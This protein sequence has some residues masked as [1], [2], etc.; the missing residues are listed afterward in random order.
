M[1][2]AALW[3]KVTS[4]KAEAGT[5]FVQDPESARYDGMPRSAIETGLADIVAR[6]E[7]MPEKLVQF[8]RHSTLSGSLNGSR[9][10]AAAE[11]VR[12]PLQQVF[13]TMR[14][15][16]GHDFSRYKLATIRRRLQ[17]RMSVNE[18][19]DTGE[20]ARYL[21]E[22]DDEVKA[23]LK[24]LLISV[25]NLFRD[26]DA[27]EA[28]RAQMLTVLKGKA[29]GSELR[30]WVAGCATGEEAYSVAIVVSECLSELEKRL[31][32]QMYGTDI[33]ID[34]LHVARTGLYPANI[35]ADVT[36]ERL[37][38]FFVKEKE[39]YRIKKDIR[40][41]VVF[42]P[43]NFIK[44]PPFSR[45]D[46]ICCR[47][48]LIYLEA[49]VQK[50]VLPLLH[51]A[52][53]PGGILFLGPS[54][55]VGEATDLFAT[56]DRKWKIYQ[57]REVTVPAERL[58]FPASFAPALRGG[59][60][61][62]GG[63]PA[64]VAEA[65]RIPQLTEKIFLDHY[66]PTFAII[67][68][69]YRLVYVRGR[70]GRFL[71]IASGQPSLSVLE[72][73]REGLR[74][75]LASAVYRASSERKLIVHDGVRVKNNGG[76]Q[77]VNLTVAPLTEPGIPPGFL[78]V[79]FQEVGTATGEEKPRPT[80][81]AHKRVAQLEEDL[82]LSRENLQTT[83]EEL[84]A[85][86][87]ELKSANEELQSNNEELQSTNEELD[88]SREELQSLNEELTTLN[89]ELQDKNELLT[90]ANDDLRNFLNR[91]DIAI[92]FLDEELKIRSFTPATADVFNIRD[93]DV[94]RPLGDIT[95]RLAYDGIVDDAQ[96]V[97]RSLKAKEVEVQRKDGCWYKLRILPYLTTQNA[98]GGLVLSLL[99]IDEQKKAVESLRETKDYLDKLFDNASAPIIVWDPKSL[100]TRFNHAF[101]KLTGRKADEVLGKRVDFLIP[102]AG[103]KGAL[104]KIN[105]SARKREP[106]DNV[107]VQIQHA[108]GSVRTL[109]WNSATVLDTDGKTPLGTIAQGVD[110][111]ERK[112]VETLKD[113][114]IGLVSHEMRTPLTVI[115][116]AVKTALDDRI[117]EA[118]RREL[119]T[120][121]SQAAESLGDILDN[122]L[123]LSRHQANRL[124]LRRRATSVAELAGQVVAE[125]RRTPL[126]HN[127][128]L[129]VPA[130]LPQIVVD[131]V[132]FQRVLHNLLENALKYAPEQTD[133]RV[134]ARLEDRQVVVG[135]SDQGPGISLEDQAKLFE[136]F[137]RLKTI[138]PT[139]GVGLG[140]VVCK[141]LVEAHGGRIWLESRPGEGST[142]LFTVPLAS[143]KAD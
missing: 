24:D 40:E 63:E 113:E 127:I 6:P 114:F 95:S 47:N 23:F 125:F 79:V 34:A 141:R 19:S 8:V 13:A 99:D 86:N 130:G 49:D 52:L 59:A 38:R 129:D 67:D 135:V 143:K 7:D 68:E 21:K 84:E 72:M 121:S 73:A 133:V 58:R 33:D 142:F 53:K 29:Q 123:E 112:N 14:A 77:T 83:I 10:G 117:S 15:R 107:E 94:G 61:T 139:S 74:T 111:T 71:E 124:E 51:Y 132:R 108:D 96:G 80:T 85:T 140:L 57:R 76:F 98:L 75:E 5:V 30:V 109:L 69:Q 88:T 48:L 41:M 93:I 42:A 64:A 3:Q 37:S 25:T 128:V 87:E 55:T 119:L 43:H 81:K 66:A 126:R 2:A 89:A 56:V 12:E 116:G 105:E 103:R 11:D 22:H 78:I 120:E 104:R 136:P 118:D 54:E 131:H 28:L 122:L 97:L 91:T 50:Q 115:N 27:F 44:D 100:I 45:M 1:T 134:F 137:Q 31:Q 90:R 138:L 82:K 92:I 106:W 9:T 26:P 20:Y 70:T 17:R 62:A 16:T 102:A 110:I 18:I 46:L 39:S 65:T 101:E 32:V 36:A 60:E 35:A 4:S